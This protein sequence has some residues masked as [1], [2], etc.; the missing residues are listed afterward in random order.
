MKSMRTL[1]LSAALALVG[2]TAVPVSAQPASRTLTM[3][4]TEVGHLQIDGSGVETWWLD[5]T[6]GQVVSVTARSDYFLPSIHIV[7]PAGEELARDDGRARLGT[8]RDPRLVAHLRT[9]GRYLVRVATQGRGASGAYRITARALE[10]RPIEPDVQARGRYENARGGDVWSFEGEAGQIA[11]VAAHATGF[12]VDLR[13]VSPTG[14]PLARGEDTR[15]VSTGEDYAHLLAT[16]PVDGRYHIEVHDVDRYWS[17]TYRIAVHTMA[18]TP[19][20][21][22]ATF[23]A[24]VTFGEPVDVYGFEGVAGQ[25]VR[26]EIPSSGEDR[27]S[28]QLTPPAGEPILDACDGVLPLS[29]S[30]RYVLGVTPGYY[31]SEES[32]PPYELTVRRVAVPSLAAGTPVSG[33]L[34]DGGPGVWGFDGA[35]DQV[36]SVAVDAPTTTPV[37]RLVA[38]GG[39]TLA[40]KSIG[41]ASWQS[42]RLV[43]QLPTDGRYL[44]EVGGDADEPEAAYR[45]TVRAGS[46]TPGRLEPDRPAA[47]VF[48]EPGL[49]LWEFDGVAGQAVSVSAVSASHERLH[50]EILSP[51]GQ[52]FAEN[53]EWSP[54]LTW[55]VL[56]PASGR[57]RVR[58]TPD[59]NSSGAYE[60][61]V[62]STAVTPTPLEMNAP[63]A[64]SYEGGI[65]AWSFE[66]MAGQIVRVTLS[67]GPIIFHVMSP[68]GERIEG[69]EGVMGPLPVDGRYVVLVMGLP[70]DSAWAYEIAVRSLADTAGS[71][72]DARD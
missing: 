71:L 22:D 27:W 13:L 14:E 43:A 3:D 30:G 63:A 31:M 40:R 20:A 49:D 64:G 17:G 72:D 18:A 48:V 25:A 55:G 21:L 59:D 67:D 37:L 11:A 29:V 57:Y 53:D 8:H 38:P 33:T 56:L 28:C 69:G 10:A 36:V 19:I 2:F 44:V 26:V 41:S 34:V 62:G 58:V 32:L 52:V 4:R 42:R 12:Q 70:D 51:S 54:W 65:D 23:P 47:G 6:A 9:S 24:G 1:R 45:L 46:E 5:G 66:G 35:A 68:A 61:A 15:L 16:L 50:L 39:E 60:L 7:S